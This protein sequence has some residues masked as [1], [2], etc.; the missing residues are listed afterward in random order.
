MNAKIDE[1]N[2]RLAPARP[3]HF[4][5]WQSGS[6]LNGGQVYKDF[7]AN[8]PAHVRQHV[9][10]RFG[11]A[12]TYPL[13]VDTPNP[14]RGSVKVNAL[15]VDGD[16]PGLANPSSPYPWTGIYFQGIPVRVEAVAEPGYRFAGWAGQPEGTPQVIEANLSSATT[17]TALFEPISPQVPIHVWDHE[18]ATQFLQ[19]SFTIGGA[20]LTATPAPGG[21]VE[22]NS[23]AQGF[24]TAHLRV[25]NPVG[26]SLRWSLPSTGYEDLRLSY[27]TRRSGQGAGQQTIE[28]SLDGSTWQLFGTYLVLDANPQ[29]RVLDFSAIPG[30]QNNPDFTIR[31]TFSRDAAQVSAGTGLGGNQ[32]FDD[33]TLSG[34]ALPGTNRPPEIIGAANLISLRIGGPAGEVD[35]NPLFSDPDGD[36]LAFTVEVDPPGAVMVGLSGNVMQITGLATGNARVTVSADDGIHEPVPL[37]IPVLVHPAA[38]GIAAA[39]FHFTRWNADHPAGTFP[40]SMLFLQGEGNNDATLST[41]LTK[42]YEIPSADAALPADSGFPYGAS[43]RTRI[44]GLGENGISFLNTGRGRDLGAALVALDTRG[45]DQVQLLWTAGTITPG[46]GRTYA[47]R[48]QARAGHAGAF[49]DVLIAGN[50]IEYQGAAIPGDTL[51]FGPIELPAVWLGQEYVQLAWRYH[52][53][54]GTSGSRDELALDDVAIFREEPAAWET[55][56][57]REFSPSERANPAISGPL[58]EHGGVANL[59]R[60]A[61]GAGR[62]DLPTE[63]L[64]RLD[65]AGDGPAFRIRG[66]PARGDVHYR[67]KQSGDLAD[68][69]TTIF[70][71]S[72]NEVT[73][74]LE[75]EDLVVPVPAGEK[76]FLRLE[77]SLP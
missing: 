7:A 37:S 35:L 63:F 24:A 61:L 76:T 57:M 66:F 58:A 50:P 44:N 30:A 42:A 29:S 34:R 72:T 17:F 16:L 62:H 46:T 53:T 36:T 52:Q 73:E 45:A 1:F 3:E 25:N 21:T 32:R 22:R 43:A 33:V 54:G 4:Q 8:R 31:A 74:F 41:A 71:S 60:Y 51:V 18:Q 48:L 27:T 14:A 39:D 69:T 68:W 23:S 9:V 6:D 77:T 28:Y 38:H 12:G 19:P 67:I 5:R 20:T 10:T 65:E 2:S 64:P 47:L 13:T 55:W 40:S 56:R 11:L 26:T 49:Q 75:G 59:M 15:L 70:D